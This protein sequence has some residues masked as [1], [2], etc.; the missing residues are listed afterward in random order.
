MFYNVSNLSYLTFL[1]VK[2]T[3]FFKC[4]LCNINYVLPAIT[5]KYDAKSIIL[6][7]PINVPN[8]FGN[9]KNIHQ[10]EIIPLI[11]IL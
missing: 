2:F 9:T 10:K 3:Y 5:Q 4:F 1:S 11:N 8:S 6:N 7:F